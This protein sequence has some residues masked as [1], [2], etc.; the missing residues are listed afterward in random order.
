MYL[1]DLVTLTVVTNCM[2]IEPTIPKRHIT[3]VY[4]YNKHFC[5]ILLNKIITY[6]KIIETHVTKKLKSY[7]T[8]LKYR[9]IVYVVAINNNDSIISSSLQ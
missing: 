3:L 8:L 5:Q 4:N 9:I 2:Y 7:S 1:F 6:I